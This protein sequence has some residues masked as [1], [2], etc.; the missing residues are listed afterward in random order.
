[1]DPSKLQHFRTLLEDRRRALR[2]SVA[3]TEQD[4]VDRASGS[5]QK[6]FLFSR[7]NTGRGSLQLVERAL[8]DIKEGAYGEC[9]HCGDEI[10]LRRLEAVPWARHC[11]RC[12]EKI[13][14][15]ELAE[16]AED[17]QAEDA[18]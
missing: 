14:R 13:E 2:E 4:I 5:Y 9:E 18:G 12:Q 6:E 15:G 7:S 16:N 1:M 8:A 17:E 3:R 11:I 10:N